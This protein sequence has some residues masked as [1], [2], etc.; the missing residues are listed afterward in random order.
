VGKGGDL[1]LVCGG[2]R[3]KMYSHCWKKEGYIYWDN[4]CHIQHNVDQVSIERGGDAC[5]Y[6]TSTKESGKFTL[7]VE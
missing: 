3:S 4:E 7:G 1:V 5:E 6:P 2:V